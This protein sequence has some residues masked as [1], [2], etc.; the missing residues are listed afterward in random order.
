MYL[1][2]L[3]PPGAGK[4]TQAKM[5]EQEFGISQISTGDIIRES[6]RQ[7]TEWGKKANEY[8]KEGKLVPDEVV[9]GIIQE[10]LSQEK[11]QAGFML[12]GFP[13]TL[14]QAE[15]LA[16]MLDNMG[17]RLDGVLYFEV[18]EEEVIQRLSARRI[19]ENCQ[20][21]YNLLSKPPKEDQICDACGGKLIQRADD[22][23]EV[24]RQR[25]KTYKE[26]T[27][28]LVKWYEDRGLLYRLK[29]EG[30]IA[31]VYQQVKKVLNEIQEKNG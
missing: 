25:L 18:N 26:Q 1:V 8:V 22:R 13:R 16:S 2:L 19:C 7:Q 28:P 20:A 6:I 10:Q 14:Q 3:G 23:P 30:S 12:D 5:I 31:E 24:I 9:I 11:F 15:A 4:G 27:A 21:T 17:K 29:S